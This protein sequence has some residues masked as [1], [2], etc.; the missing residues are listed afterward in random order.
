MPLH[1]GWTGRLTVEIPTPLVVEIDSG[2]PGEFLN[3]V[4]SAIPDFLI[5]DQSLWNVG[6]ASALGQE[7]A[8]GGG[9]LDG[10]AS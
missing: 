2:Q 7:R 8:E 1:G 4:R 5:Q 3:L 6:N 9:V 10:N